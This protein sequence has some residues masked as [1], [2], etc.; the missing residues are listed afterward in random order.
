MKATIIRVDA[1]LDEKD[2]KTV[3]A[4]TEEWIFLE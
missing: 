3:R 1:Q 4:L 2:E